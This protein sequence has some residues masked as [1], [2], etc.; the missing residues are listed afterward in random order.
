MKMEKLPLSPN[1]YR[2]IG[3]SRKQCFL[4]RQQAIM[5]QDGKSKNDC[6]RNAAKRFLAYF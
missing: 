3:S 2:C 6:E 5:K 1:A 4:L